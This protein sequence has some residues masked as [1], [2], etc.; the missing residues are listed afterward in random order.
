[1]SLKSRWASSKKN[2][3]FGCGRSP[4][5]GSVSNSSDSIHSNAVAYTFGDRMS[6]SAARDVDDAAAVA[7]GLDQV[8]KI[9]CRL[10]EKFATALGF[11][12]RGAGVG[13]P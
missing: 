12:G 10:P 9:E 6:R 4:A 5:S 1:M 2:T 8:L 7:V 13:W 3:S 11:E